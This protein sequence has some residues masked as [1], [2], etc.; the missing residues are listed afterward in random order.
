MGGNKLPISLSKP[1]KE[2]E[3]IDRFVSHCWLDNL[4][5]KFDA[6]VRFSRYFKEQNGRLPRLWIDMF[7]INQEPT[8]LNMN[9]R[10]LPVFLM[11]CDK[12]LCLR[13]PRLLNRMWCLTE[14]YTYWV[15]S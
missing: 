3:F 9:L 8:E 1:C 5:A 7:C 12:I 10:C 4:D 6:L 14:L 13:S 15:L 11:S 2:G